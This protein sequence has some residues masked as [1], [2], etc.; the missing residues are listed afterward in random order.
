MKKKESRNVSSNGCYLILTL[1]LM[2]WLLFSGTASCAEKD[3]KRIILLQT[4]PVPVV[5]EQSSWFITQLHELGYIEGENLDLVV[6]QADGD[7]KRAENILRDA[8]SQ[9]TPDLVATS[10]TLASQTAAQVLKDSAVPIVFFTVSD[11]VGAGLIKEIGVP[12]STNITGKVHMISREVRVDMVMR[13]IGQVVSGRPVRIGFIHSSYP[14]S[15]GDIR[16]MQELAQA[17]DDLDFIPYRLEYRRVP[18]GLGA[19]LTEA[20]Q[21]LEQ[22]KE[23]VDCWWEPSGPLGEVKEYTEMFKENSTLPVV[24]GTK[25]QSVKSGA[26]LHLTP[27]TEQE[28]REAALIAE[29]ILQGAIAGR[30]APTPPSTFEVGINLTTA[31]KHNIVIPP[32]ILQLAG[33]QAFH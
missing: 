21:G 30:I 22:L 32:D 20:R 19:M 8:I 15:L 26:L 4:M 17:R 12:T 3:T 16:E 27:S 29:S 5:M 14:S 1:G 28:G 6:L 2:V 33:D 7:R 10:A 25:M 13:L 18:E 24:M 11:P 23:K 9:K 31:L